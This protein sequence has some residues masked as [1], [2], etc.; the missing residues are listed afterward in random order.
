MPSGGIRKSA[1]G[2]VVVAV[3]AIAAVFSLLFGEA[4]NA[5]V[6]QSFRTG[7][8]TGVADNSCYDQGL[9]DQCFVLPNGVPSSITDIPSFYNYIKGEYNSGNTRRMTGASFVVNTMLGHSQPRGTTSLSAADWSDWLDRM[10]ALTK[11]DWSLSNAQCA[12][13]DTGMNASIDVYRVPYGACGT[14]IDFYDGGTLVYRLNRECANPDGQLPG[15]P[16]AKKWTIATSTSLTHTTTTTTP[17]LGANEVIP[18]DIVTWTHTIKNTG[19]DSTTKDVAWNYVNSNGWSGTGGNA[20]FTAG[21]ANGATAS[22]TYKYTIQSSDLGKTL[23]QSTWAQPHAWNDASATQSAPPVC[24]TVVYRYELTPNISVGTS[25]IQAGASGGSVTYSVGNTG[26]TDA[27]PTTQWV[28]TSCQYGP[29]QKVPNNPQLTKVT[30]TGQSPQAYY[31]NG[32]SNSGGTR[33]FPRNVNTQPQQPDPFSVNT[34]NAAAGTHFCYGLS[35]HPPGT[36]EPASQW[37]HSPL[38]CIAIV[39]F[40]KVQAWSG[41][42][43][44][45]R[46]TTTQP[47]NLSGQFYGS[48]AQYGIFGMGG[49]S[50]MA[51]GGTLAGGGASSSGSVLSALTFANTPGLGNFY[52][53]NPSTSNYYATYKALATKTTGSATVGGSVPNG[54]QEIIYVNGD[55]TIG[56]DLTY[57]GNYG[58]PSDVPRVIYVV[59]GNIIVNQNVQRVDAWLISNKT[60]YTCDQYMN[61]T[62][63]LTTN[64]CNKQLTFN[65][66]VY[67]ND[68]LLGR[69]YGADSSTGKG[70]AA[71]I[72]NLAP[73]NFLS[74][75]T[76]SVSASNVQTEYEKE[77]PPRW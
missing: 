53:V 41:D 7:Y 9:A 49:I 33:S 10:N 17:K 75:Y 22:S 69:T 16:V 14:Y 20:T 8:F 43:L 5:S 60:L 4:A 25:S 31:G 64:D 71:E 56:S 6:W 35:L 54:T 2:R 67:V 74:S 30:T 52:S 58:S 55:L 72:F 39:K 1:V 15:L 24:V 23:C 12:Q 45:G 38:V 32:C 76:A 62:K 42:V 46:V 19:P 63:Q 48:W 11:I 61:K 59:N 13:Y 18:G 47:Y 73:S 37:I 29:T 36:S 3:F 57:S 27:P 34:A 68:T 28:L 26:P 70:E 65:G 40:P 77:L 44:A 66:P 50:G 21:Q 51:S